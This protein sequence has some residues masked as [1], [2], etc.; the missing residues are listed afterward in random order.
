MDN[1]LIYILK[2]NIQIINIYINEQLFIRFD[3]KDDIKIRSYFKSSLI[4]HNHMY[5]MILNTLTR[6]YNFIIIIS[7]FQDMN[8]VKY[9]DINI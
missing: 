3:L 4:Y 6:S 8:F 9:I 7:F 5:F 2:N 1:K